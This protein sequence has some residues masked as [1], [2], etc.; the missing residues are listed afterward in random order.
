MMGSVRLKNCVTV[1]APSTEAASYICSSTDWNAARMMSMVN[2]AIFQVI[3]KIIAGKD[4]SAA[5]IQ[6]TGL[7]MIWNLWSR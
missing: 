1:L 3:I 6:R 7:S 2:P 5:F 4:V